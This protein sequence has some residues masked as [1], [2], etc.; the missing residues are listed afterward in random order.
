MSLCT[1]PYLLGDV[2]SEFDE[3]ERALR[4][5]SRKDGAACGQLDKVTDDD[6]KLA[7]SLD[8][9]R[10]KPDDLKVNLEDRILTVEGKQEIKEGN[11]YSLRSFVRQWAL[12]NDVN[13]DELRSSI[14]EDGHLSIEAPKIKAQPAINAKSIPIQKAVKD[15]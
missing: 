13:V 9:S 12:P 11:G 7:I 2:F 8:V 5:H 1:L 10:F 14:T 6:S 4:A 15:Q 3:L